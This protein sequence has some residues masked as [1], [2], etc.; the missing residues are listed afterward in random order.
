MANYYTHLAFE[1]PATS[2]D[3]E[4]FNEA[5]AAATVAGNS[6]ADDNDAMEGIGCRFD[7]DSGTLAIFDSDGAP[8][9]WALATSLQRLFPEKLPLGFVYSCSC[10]KPRSDGFGGGLFAVG[11]EN[12]V[13]CDLSELLAEE[14]ADL[15]ENPDVG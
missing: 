5:I 14:I 13:Q 2:D 12:I 7:Q 11:S 8:N 10:D 3:A 1:I 4:R 15:T 9:L 6:G